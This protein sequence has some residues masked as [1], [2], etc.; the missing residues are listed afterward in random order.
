MPQ[1]QP[2][3]RSQRSQS[4]GNVARAFDEL[5]RR[6]HSA[7]RE[8]RVDDRTISR[9]TA[10]IA[11]QRVV[12]LG[13]IG[14]RGVMVQREQRHHE[15][16]RAETALRRMLFHHGGLHRMRRAVGLAQMLDCQNLLA[17]QRGREHDT[18]IHRAVPHAVTDRFPQRDGAGAAIALRAT[19]FCPTQ[20]FDSPQVFEDG[21]C[22]ADVAQFAN[23]AAQHKARALSHPRKLRRPAVFRVDPF[24]LSPQ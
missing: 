12:H 1:F 6:P 5:I 16:G 9:A 4:R 15:A 21:H 18:G 22:R 14:R 19:F 8:R 3:V 23:V 20:L 2:V 24:M 7:D 17:V 11:R 13:A 10:E